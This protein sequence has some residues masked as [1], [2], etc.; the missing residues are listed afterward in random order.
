MIANDKKVV[1]KTLLKQKRRYDAAFVL[2]TST[3]KE[4]F[5]Y[6]V[7]KA[8][9][10]YA[11]GVVKSIIFSGKWWGGLIKKPKHTEAELMSTYARSLGVP[12]KDIYLEED[13]LN[14]IGNYYFTKKNI[15]KPR[16][17]KN[18]VVITHSTHVSKARFIAQKVLGSEYK[19]RFVLDKKQVDVQ[20]MHKNVSDIKFFF[21]AI[22]NGDDASI[23]NLLTHHPYYK[24][25]QK[26]LKS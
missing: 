26:I 12:K 3:N 15:L 17:I 20:V 25:H 13:S 7:E 24:N 22:K 10:L 4:I 2:G 9:D 23:K 6:R 16:N 5:K 18:L 14:T 19:T 11:R 21:K 1:V 8:A